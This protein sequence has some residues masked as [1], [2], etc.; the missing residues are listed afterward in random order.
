MEW[1]SFKDN[2]SREET[3]SG[4]TEPEI[5]FEV[6]P[7]AFGVSQMY[8]GARQGENGNED[9]SSVPQDQDRNEAAWSEQ[10]LR[11][12]R[13]EEKRFFLH[14][15]S[16]PCRQVKSNSNINLPLYQHSFSFNPVNALMFF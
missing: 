9:V 14:Q 4:E 6:R 7:N 12:N 1:V 8:S 3:V 5:K 16:S 2:E 13:R 10:E 11:E 15:S